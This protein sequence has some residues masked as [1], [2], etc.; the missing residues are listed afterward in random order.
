VCV[1]LV[2]VC[3]L[4]V[5]ACVCVCVYVVYVCVC[6]SE[7]YLEPL[8]TYNVAPGLTYE[9]VCVCACARACVCVRVYVC[10]C[11]CVCVCLCVCVCVCV[12]IVGNRIQSICEVD[13]RCGEH[14]FNMQCVTVL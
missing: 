7:F 9:C 11:V 1:L 5:D 14:A 12:T 4:P 2:N 3:A 6:A 8:G 13:F 10:V